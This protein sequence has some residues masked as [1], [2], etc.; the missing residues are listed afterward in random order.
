MCTWRKAV[1]FGAS[2]TF[3]IYSNIFGWGAGG[4]LT[5]PVQIPINLY[6]DFEVLKIIRVAPN[7][8]L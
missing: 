7:T 2:E 4:N 8:G 6:F 3:P 5:P 1:I